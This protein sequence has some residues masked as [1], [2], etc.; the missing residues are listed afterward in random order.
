MEKI[1][2]ELNGNNQ[3]KAKLQDNAEVINTFQVVSGDMFSCIHEPIVRT[4]HREI[5]FNPSCVAKIK[6]D[7]AELLLRHIL[8]CSDLYPRS[9]L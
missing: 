6:T 3:N 8:K 2:D 1:K 7:Y 4:G 5:S 9:P